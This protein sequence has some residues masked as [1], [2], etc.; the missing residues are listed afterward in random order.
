MI[1]DEGRQKMG[2]SFDYYNLIE[3]CLLDVELKEKEKK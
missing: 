2:S 3:K 1:Y